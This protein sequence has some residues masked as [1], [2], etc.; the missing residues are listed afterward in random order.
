MV[1]KSAIHEQARQA[2]LFSDDD[3]RSTVIG[4]FK[5]SRCGIY[6]GQSSHA[7]CHKCKAAY[8]REWRKSHEL[9]LEQKVKDNA[10]SY[11]GVYKRRGKLQKRPCEHCGS[12]DSQMH[13]PDYAQPLKVI[14]LCRD[15]H[16]DLHRDGEEHEER[17]AA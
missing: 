17:R 13:H 15:C 2:D 11:A 7:Y 1:K 12:R 6:H 16:L 9:T 4:P 5:C 14:W 3:G 8:M 10:R